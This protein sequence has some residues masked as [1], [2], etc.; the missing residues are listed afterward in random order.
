MTTMKMILK[1]RPRKRRYP[2]R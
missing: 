2:M 1:P